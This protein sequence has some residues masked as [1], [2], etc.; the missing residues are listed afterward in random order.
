MATALYVKHR[1]I[2]EIDLHA[3]DRNRKDVFCTTLLCVSVLL[4]NNK[5][6]QFF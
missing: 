2:H 3:A 5:I 1:V 4:I 6:A